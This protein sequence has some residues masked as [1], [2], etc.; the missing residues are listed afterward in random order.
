MMEAGTVTKVRPGI[1]RSHML[2]MAMRLV[3]RWVLQQYQQ[4]DLAESL[5]RAVH[6]IEIKNQKIKYFDVG[7]GRPV[8]LLHGLGSSSFSWLPTLLASG[9][10]LRL[11]APDQIGHGRSDKPHI[12]YR[13]SEFVEYLE[14]FIQ[15]LDL[16]EVDLVGNSLGGWIAGRLAVKRPDL[17]RRLIL[18]CSAGLQPRPEVRARLEKVQFAPRTYAQTKEILSLCFYD[19]ERYASPASAAITYML[20]RLEANHTTVERILRA[21]LDPSE[22]MDDKMKMVRSRTMVLWGRKDE[23]L[24]VEFASQYASGIEGSRLEIFE[25]CGHVPQIE[26]ARDFNNL[27]AD[28]LC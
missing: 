10:D 27:I 18:V 28:F 24:P 6:T 17:V 21:V 1:I 4:Q 8:I 20:R 23:L 2:D 14:A 5:S 19:K 26:R 9:R 7:K 16:K 15:K 11:I 22:W 13:I 3:G 12:E 25:R